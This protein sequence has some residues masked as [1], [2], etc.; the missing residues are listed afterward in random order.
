[1]KRFY[2]VAIIGLIAVSSLG[3]RSGRW[4]AFRDS[5]LGRH[6]EEC[7]PCNDCRMDAG[8]IYEG[9][10]VYESVPSSDGYIAPPSATLPAPAS[11]VSP[12]T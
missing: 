6:Q 10:P 4:A 8:V 11:Y 2:V 12:S 5:C 7:V 3:C 1:M 9:G